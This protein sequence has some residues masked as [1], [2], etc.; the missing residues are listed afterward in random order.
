MRFPFKERRGKKIPLILVT[1]AY[2]NNKGDGRHSNQA[3]R[4]NGRNFHG[5][6]SG[7][8]VDCVQ[9]LLTPLLSPR[10]LERALYQVPR[11]ATRRPPAEVS[12]GFA[13]STRRPHLLG[14]A[15]RCSPRSATVRGARAKQC[16]SSA[17][18][19]G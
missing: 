3:D 5:S 18:F 13:V 4:K 9:N 14:L 19:L 15:S 16:R 11:C 7:S 17:V 2:W 12:S 10:P 1:V 8:F 6:R